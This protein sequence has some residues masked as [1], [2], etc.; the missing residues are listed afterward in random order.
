MS[1]GRHR[2]PETEKAKPKRL[3]PAGKGQTRPDRDDSSRYDDPSTFGKGW[4]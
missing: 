2:A 1:G 3:P 4:S